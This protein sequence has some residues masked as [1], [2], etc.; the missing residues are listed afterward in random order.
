MGLRLVE[1]MRYWPPARRAYASERLMIKCVLTVKLK[2]ANILLKTN[3]PVFH[4]S[5]IPYSRQRLRL[6]KCLIFSLSYR[7]SETF[8]TWR[9]RRK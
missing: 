5:N 2:L 4:Y 7:N 8:I 1:I 3:F 6:K 9:V